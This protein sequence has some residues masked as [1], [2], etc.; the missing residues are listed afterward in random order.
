MIILRS[1]LRLNASER[2]RNRFENQT[3]SSVLG[4]PLSPELDQESS[5]PFAI[6]RKKTE[7]NWTFPP[8]ATLTS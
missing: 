4:S 8:L 6:I 7:L 2:E 3:L 5:S 1:V